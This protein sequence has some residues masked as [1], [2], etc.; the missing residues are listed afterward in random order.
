MIQLQAQVAHLQAELA[1]PMGQNHEQKAK[2]ITKSL[3]DAVD[4]VVWRA[5]ILLE[6]LDGAEGDN[7]RYAAIKNLTCAIEDYEASRGSGV[8]GQLEL[9]S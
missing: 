4:C 5:R 8:Q 3:A 1:A 2:P 7:R 9:R 6:D